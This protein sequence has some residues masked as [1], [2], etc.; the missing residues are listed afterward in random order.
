[1]LPVYYGTSSLTF[2]QMSGLKGALAIE[3]INKHQNVLKLMFQEHA[4]DWPGEKVKFQPS[5]LYFFPAS[6][7]CAE[8]CCQSTCNWGH[9]SEQSAKFEPWM[10]HLS[11]L[12]INKQFTLKAI[13]FRVSLCLV[14][15]SF[16]KYPV[17]SI[18]VVSFCKF[19]LMTMLW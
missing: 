11:V 13:L 17:S 2:C 16:H 9:L 19:V 7:I 3:K 15:V 10:K 6:D 4:L 1:M 14:Q 8:Q 18:M 12:D 5:Y